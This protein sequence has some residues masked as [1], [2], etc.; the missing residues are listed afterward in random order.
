MLTKKNLHAIE[1]GEQVSERAGGASTI[2]F[3]DES[4]TQAID[5]SR[6][7]D[8]VQIEQGLRGVLSAISVSRVDDGNWRY[9]GGAASSAFLMVANDDH[10]GSIRR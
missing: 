8:R 7:I 9:F 10:V 6:A 4:D 3:A 5:G 2:E 1:L